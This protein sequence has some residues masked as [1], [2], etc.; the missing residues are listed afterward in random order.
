M[1]THN[2]FMHHLLEQINQVSVV[3]ETGMRLA[4]SETFIEAHKN[5]T[6]HNDICCIGVD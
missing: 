4:L 6:Q 5:S 2:L 1:K 3:E